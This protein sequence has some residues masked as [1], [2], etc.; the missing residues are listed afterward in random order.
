MHNE[1]AHYLNIINEKKFTDF[2]FRVVHVGDETRYPDDN[3]CKIMHWHQDLQFMYVQQ[4]SIIV[5]TLS[6]TITVGHGEGIFI[7]KN[8]VHYIQH[9]A[10]TIYYSFV[11]PEHFLTFYSDYPAKEMVERITENE[12]L[13][14]VHF[15]PT[16]A[17]Q[18]E[19]ISFL[20]KLERLEREKSPFYSYEILV[21]L[22][23]LWLIMRKNLTLPEKE[24]SNHRLRQKMQIFLRYINQHYAENMTLAQLADS[25][26]VSKSGCLRYFKIS[27]N[28]TPYNYLVEFRILKALQLLK[29]SDDSIGNIALA[30]GFQ[31]LSHFGKCFRAKTGL[32]P[33]Q[34]RE[35]LK[36]QS[37]SATG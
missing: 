17:W 16:I 12:H 20:E 7:N 34:Y 18:Q 4:G 15:V 14:L 6:Q 10:D 19:I 32:S 1:R 26:N 22:T 5:Q 37:I 3:H 13:P 30:V 23:S 9:Q 25:A 28:T 31:Q 33:R 27:L 36:R 24:E 21:C 11:F 2:P 29:D 8:V 35:Q